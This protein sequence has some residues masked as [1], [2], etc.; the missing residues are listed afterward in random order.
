MMP[1]DF[2]RRRSRKVPKVLRCFL[3]ILSGTLP[4]P[5][6]ATASSASSLRVLGLVERPGERDYRLVDPRLVGVANTAIAARAPA[7]KIID[8]GEYLRI[9]CRFRCD[10]HCLTPLRRFAAGACPRAGCRRR[11][12]ASSWRRGGRAR[13]AP[14]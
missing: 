4:R 14:G 11:P 6:S 10:S 9:G 2:T 3:V 7:K 8:D 1:T 13:P 5:V 12:P